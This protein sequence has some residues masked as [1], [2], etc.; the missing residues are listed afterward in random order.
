MRAD[1]LRRE[2]RQHDAEFLR[3]LVTRMLGRIEPEDVRNT[4]YVFIRIIRATA[5]FDGLDLRQL[6]ELEAKLQS[7]RTLE[8]RIS[9]EANQIIIDFAAGR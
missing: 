7:L 2:G 5:R 4:T 3:A 1:L 9:A 6:E 8:D